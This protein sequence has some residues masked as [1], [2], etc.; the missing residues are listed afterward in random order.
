MD[1]PDIYESAPDWWLTQP[2]KLPEPMDAEQYQREQ[3]ATAQ[4]EQAFDD[5]VK[6]YSRG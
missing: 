4:S 1:T 6:E 2:W 3:I 5:N